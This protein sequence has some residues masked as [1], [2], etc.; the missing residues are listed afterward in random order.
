M[1]GESSTAAAA[2]R[3]SRIDSAV[4]ESRGGLKRKKWKLKVKM[5]AKALP[6]DDIFGIVLI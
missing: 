6:L 5:N 3:E 2:G 1:P 4:S